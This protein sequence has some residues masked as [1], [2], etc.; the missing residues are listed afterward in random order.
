[1][2][3]LRPD[4]SAIT[5]PKAKLTTTTHQPLSGQQ[6]KKHEPKTNCDV[7]VIGGAGAALEAAIAARQSGAERGRHAGE[8]ASTVRRQRAVSHV[9]SVSCIG[10]Q[11]CA[12]SYRRSGRAVSASADP[13]YSRQNFIDDLNRVTQGRIDPVLTECLVD[14]SNAAVHW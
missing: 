10:A 7:I 11:E 1:V 6:S 8:G 14:R 9:G 12:R 3:R 4:P 2:R 5:Y 13:V